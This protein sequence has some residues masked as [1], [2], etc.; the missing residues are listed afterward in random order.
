M[1]DVRETSA[2]RVANSS[3]IS[4]LTSRDTAPTK[5]H[6]YRGAHRF[7]GLPGISIVR[8]QQAHRTCVMWYQWCWSDGCVRSAETRVGSTGTLM[9]FHDLYETQAIS[10]PQGGEVK[11]SSMLLR[12]RGKVRSAA[13]SRSQGLRTHARRS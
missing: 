11:E 9:R 10:K 7:I 4:S 2:S 3:L 1:D 12:V 8:F 13:G 5:L 6:I